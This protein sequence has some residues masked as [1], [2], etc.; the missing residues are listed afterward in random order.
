[1]TVKGKIEDIYCCLR[2]IGCSRE[3]GIANVINLVETCKN[4]GVVVDQNSFRCA[5][6]ACERAG[7]CDY[8]TNI[9]NS[10]QVCSN[11]KKSYIVSWNFIV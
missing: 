8:G 1:M 6:I 10:M 2:N 4:R 11:K 7:R 9:F 5:M 3:V